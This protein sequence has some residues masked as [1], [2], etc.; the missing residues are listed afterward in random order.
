MR[1]PTSAGEGQHEDGEG[2]DDIAPE[3][4]AVNIGLLCS[5]RLIV[6]L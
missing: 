4:R 6:L 2:T 1:H 3:A 5:A